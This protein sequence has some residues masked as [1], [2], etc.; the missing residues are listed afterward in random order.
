[1]D[2][3]PSPTPDIEKTPETVS[4]PAETAEET[5]QKS[6]VLLDDE[7]G[8]DLNEIY[9]YEEGMVPIKLVPSTSTSWSCSR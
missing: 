4:T 1:M 7:E 2:T 8:D 3:D 9:I 5:E 6:D